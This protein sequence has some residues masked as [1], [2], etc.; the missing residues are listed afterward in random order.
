MNQEQELFHALTGCYIAGQTYNEYCAILKHIIPLTPVNG[1]FPKGNKA[2]KVIT[3]ES[4]QK[5]DK[6]CNM[7]GA[8]LKRDPLV[9][10][11]AYEEVGKLQN[12]VFQAVRLSPR[13]Q[14]RVLALMAKIKNDPSEKEFWS[15]YE[16]NQIP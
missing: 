6:H 2:L 15:Q 8:F 12:L 16:E 5:S 3:E 1:K 9:Y 4:E 11:N 14:E 7:I 10:Q 13:G